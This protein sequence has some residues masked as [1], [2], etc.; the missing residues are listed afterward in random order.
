MNIMVDPRVFRGSVAAMRREQ[1]R[2]IRM[3]L[4]AQRA[5]ERYRADQLRSKLTLMIGREG[6]GVS[7]TKSLSFSDSRRSA[8]EMRRVPEREKRHRELARLAGPVGRR[9]GASALNPL[10]QLQTQTPKLPAITSATMHREGPT[11]RAI[12]S[13]RVSGEWPKTVGFKNVR[14]EPLHPLKQETGEGSAVSREFMPIMLAQH[15]ILC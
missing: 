14:F 8:P 9:H 2:Q 15:Y 10:E 5:E 12:Q 13:V 7:L 1:Q 6:S 4:D 11:G 3:Q